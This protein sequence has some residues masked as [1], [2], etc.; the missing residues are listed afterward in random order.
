MIEYREEIYTYTLHANKT[1]Q[2]I[3]IPFRAPEQ[4]KLI[5]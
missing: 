4:A 2:I 3:Q 1:N 5:A